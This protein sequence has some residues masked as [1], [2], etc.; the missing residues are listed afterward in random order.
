M[1][2]AAVALVTMPNADHQNVYSGADACKAC[3]VA[4]SCYSE[5]GCQS[6]TNLVWSGFYVGCN[7][8]ASV[9]ASCFS[10]SPCGSAANS[11]PTF[12]TTE[13]AWQFMKRFPAPALSNGGA[14]SR[15]P[16]SLLPVLFTLLAIRA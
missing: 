13:F 16:N 7:Q 14:C 2:G 9:C 3:A 4:E 5:Q 10:D 1:G 11:A 8:G 6:Q 15:L 12:D